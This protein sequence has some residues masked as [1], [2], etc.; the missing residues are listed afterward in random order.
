MALTVTL[1]GVVTFNTTGGNTTV[2]ATPAAGDMIVVVTAQTGFT[3]ASVADNNSAGHGTYTSIVSALKSTSADQLAAF[4]RADPIR[5]AT[6]TTFTAT[7]TGSTGGGLAVLKITGATIS[8]AAFVRNTGSQANQ[9]AG[10]P[11]VPMGSAVLTTNAVVAAFLDTTNAAPTLTAPAGFSAAIVN[12]NYNTPATGFQINTANS[13]VTSSTFTWGTA[14][15]SAF[16]DIGFELRANIGDGKVGD[17]EDITHTRQIAVKHSALFC[18]GD[19]WARRRRSG[20]VVP[21]WVGA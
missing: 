4:V 12:T 3:A 14:A 1:L 18:F 13:G 9:A 16:C 8:G 17:Q 21:A 11:A 15:P 5:S 6:S 2:V 19:K 7:Q 10:T 20:L